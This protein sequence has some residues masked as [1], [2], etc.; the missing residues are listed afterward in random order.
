D[1][2]ENS[3]LVPWMV[4]IAAIHTMFA[5]KRSKS[6]HRAAILLS[7]AAYMLVI[8]STFLTRS[9][10]LGDISVHSFVDLGLSNQLLIWILAMG[11][12]GFGL[13]AHRYSD[14]PKPEREAH[15]MSRE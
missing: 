9:G 1:P 8:Y 6:N 13:F 4:G 10:I 5:R 14:L 7:V 11:V 2:V 12:V 15:V 3:S